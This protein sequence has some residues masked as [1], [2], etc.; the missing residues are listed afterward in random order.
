MATEPPKPHPKKGLF[1]DRIV[2]LGQV[3]FKI[4]FIACA[5]V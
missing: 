4:S 2:F 1:E 3:D 5:A